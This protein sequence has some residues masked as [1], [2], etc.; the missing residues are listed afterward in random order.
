M[1][2]EENNQENPQ[3]NVCFLNNKIE[4]FD[5]PPSLN[6]FR[7]KIKKLLQIPNQY[8]E[9]YITYFLDERDNDN[10]DPKE[11]FYEIKRDDEYKILLDLIRQEEI[12]GETIYIETERIPEEISRE[13]STTFE[14]EIECLVKAQLKAAGE[15]I[16]KG[17]SGK[18]ELNPC[19]K[20]QKKKC[21]KCGEFI[22]GDMFRG[23]CDKERK[24]Y[25]N[26]C[27]YIANMPMFVIH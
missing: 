11:L 3:I 1:S 23:V 24:I 10:E 8:D 9:I 13:A 26:K 22:I 27:S 21:A 16:K 4:D 12:K 25:C 2:D 18:M 5:L 7:I 6:E 14:Q 20:Q 15:R 17:L 19:S